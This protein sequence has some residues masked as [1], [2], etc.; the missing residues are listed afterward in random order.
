MLCKAGASFGVEIDNVVNPGLLECFDFVL[1]F[2]EGGNG[3][4]M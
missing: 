3:G 1:I 2:G 4:V